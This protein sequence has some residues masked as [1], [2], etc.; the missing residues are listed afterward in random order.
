MPGAL[1]V[2]LAIALFSL[3]TVMFGGYSLL[4]LLVRRQLNDFQ[5]MYFRAGHAHAGVLLILSLVVLDILDR[6]GVS[7]GTLAAVGVLLAAGVLAQSGGM[8]VHMAAGQPGKWSVGNTVSVAGAVALA[9]ALIVTAV[10]V[11]AA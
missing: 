4:R 6:A 5:A 11:I 9:T 2:F 7:T 1:K 8:F 10:E 3:P